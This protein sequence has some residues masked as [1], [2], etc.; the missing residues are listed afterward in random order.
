[1][2]REAEEKVTI[3]IWGITDAIWHSI[4]GNLDFRE[5]AIECFVDNNDYTNGMKYEGVRI[6][7]YNNEI[8]EIIDKVDYILIAAYSG[9]QSICKTLIDD[10]VCTDK[11]QLYITRE[12]KAYSIGQLYNVDYSLIDRIYIDPIQRK[13]D[14][15][16]YIEVEKAYQLGKP[17]KEDKDQWYNLGTIIAHACGGIVNGRKL[18]YTNSKEALMYTLENTDLNLIECDICGIEKNEVLLANDYSQIR[19]AECEHYT[20]MTINDILKTIVRYPTVR[21]LFDVKWNHIDEYEFYVDKI[22]QIIDEFGSEDERNLLKKQVVMEVYDEKSILCAQRAGFECFYTQYRNPDLYNYMQIALTCI[23]YNVGV[24]GYRYKDITGNANKDC[25]SI[26]K[27][28]NIKV[29]AYSCN[30]L[31]EYRL[32]KEKGLDGVFSD[33]LNM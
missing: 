13:R 9:Y 8:R 23:K 5:T 26:F 18:S 30:T 10:G 25:L 19:E 11:I 2:Q 6:Y 22:K 28:K 4:K 16:K 32:G 24:V 27:Q 7:K 3:V 1:M 15:Q 31:S 29:F 17:I 21:V 12:L 20:L 14:V 33:Y